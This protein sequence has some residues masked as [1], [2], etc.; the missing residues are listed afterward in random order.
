MKKNLL[1]SFT[2]LSL[3]LVICIAANG[4]LASTNMQPSE[5]IVSSGKL[6][7]NS[8]SVDRNNVNS[9][10]VKNFV[11]S[12][13]TV[14]N[15]KWF[16]LQDGFVALFSLDVIHYQVAYGK[17]GTWLYTIRT[18]DETKLPVDVRRLVKSTYYDY[19]ITV[20][21]EIERDPQTFER[22]SNT[23]TYLIHLEGKTNWITLKVCNG[24][25]EESQKFNKSE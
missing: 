3:L 17:N 9:K 18:Y 15:E 5:D 7:A 12:F 24:E 19:N 25:M 23:L 8:I 16:E 4:Q 22:D 21:Q 1:T 6:L 14:S 20:I 11:R 2:G 13:N 10:V